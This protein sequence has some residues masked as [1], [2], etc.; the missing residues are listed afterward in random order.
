[1]NNRIKLPVITMVLP[2]LLSKAA[3]TTTTMD[4]LFTD[5]DAVG[6]GTSLRSAVPTHPDG[7]GALFECAAGAQYKA[8]PPNNK[9]S[10]HISW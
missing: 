7:T 3:T 9:F 10:T 8:E 2:T 1:M 4:S 6:R 5:N